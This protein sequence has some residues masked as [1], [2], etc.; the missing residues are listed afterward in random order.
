MDGFDEL[1]GTQGYGDAFSSL[2]NFLNR[3]ESVGAMVVSARSAFYEAEIVQR[4]SLDASNQT[5]EARFEVVPV[6]LLEWGESEL[7]RFLAGYRKSGTVINEDLKRLNVLSSQDKDLL[8]KPFFAAKFPEYVDE[9]HAKGFLEFLADAYIR[10]ESEKIVG[11]DGGPLMTPEHHQRIFVGIAEEMWVG[12]R[13]RDLKKGDLQTVVE[14]A[15]HDFNLPDD[16]VAQVKEKIGSY[17]GIRFVQRGGQERFLF[18]H[19]VYFEHFLS[20]MI[21]DKLLEGGMHKDHS[22]V[23]DVGVFPAVAVRLAIQDA[24]TAGACLQLVNDV[25]QKANLSKENRALNLGQMLASSF[26]LLGEKGDVCGDIDVRGAIFRDCTFGK[27]QLEKVR[28]FECRFDGVTL[29][30]CSLN[31]CVAEM[32]HADGPLIVSSDTRLGITGFIP[33]QNVRVIRYHDRKEDKKEDVWDPQRMVEII[34]RL[35]DGLSGVS[36]P[37]YSYSEKAQILIRLMRR[38]ANAFRTSSTLCE[39]D[40]NLQR[41]FRAPEWRELREILVDHQ[42]IVE[43]ERATGHSSKMRMFLRKAVSS[44]D[45]VLAHEITPDENLPDGKIGDFWRTLRKIG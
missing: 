10:R 7:H 2:R 43:N 34:D 5:D 14:L 33:G 26:A 32:C 11:R 36:F 23:L 27:A 13:S 6:S 44:M 8:K 1:L 28:F 45:D 42:M 39:D 30:D 17:A 24:K 22:S 31:K 12:G 3:L 15:L 29:S 9:Y 18:E 25:S 37:V 38:V 41:V 16:T 35:G 4:A 20:Q 21:R 40:A 19:D